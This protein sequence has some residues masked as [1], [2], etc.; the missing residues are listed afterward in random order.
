MPWSLHCHAELGMAQLRGGLAGAFGQDVADAL[1]EGDLAGHL[2]HAVRVA[3]GQ[4]VAVGVAALG[5][6]HVHRQH[7]A[8]FDGVV[9]VVVGAVDHVGDRSDVVIAADGAHRPGRLV[10]DALH[11][12]LERPF[13]DLDLF[14]AGHRAGVAGGIVHQDVSLTYSPL[15]SSAC[16]PKEVSWP[17]R[18]GRAPMSL[19][20]FISTLVP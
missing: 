16:S 2:D 1:A 17:L 4:P 13:L 12:D 3:P 9:A 10:L 7:G 15:S 6:L 20:M 8:D 19:V 5:V 11:V 14:L 18:A